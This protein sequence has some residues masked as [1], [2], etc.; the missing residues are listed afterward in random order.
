MNT[1]PFSDMGGDKLKYVHKWNGQTS[2]LINGD[3]VFDCPEG[4]MSSKIW[5]NQN[6]SDEFYDGW[7]NSC[8]YMFDT[9]E[10]W[11]IL[12]NNAGIFYWE[13]SESRYPSIGAEVSNINH[14]YYTTEKWS[15]DGFLRDSVVDVQFWMGGSHND[16]LYTEPIFVLD[17]WVSSDGSVRF[18]HNARFNEE[19]M[20]SGEGA[21]YEWD[22]SYNNVNDLSGWNVVHFDG[23]WLCP[24]MDDIINIYNSA[25]TLRSIGVIS[26]INFD[27]SGWKVVLRDEENNTNGADNKNKELNRES[28]NSW[29]E[30]RR[31]PFDD[32]YYTKEEFN[33]YYG[34]LIQWDFMDPKKEFKRQI[35]SRW[36]Y[37]NKD[38]MRDSA[39]LHLMDEMFKTFL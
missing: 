14:I 26:Q 27:N 36:I 37:D 19:A 5:D 38:Y 30:R 18:V 31:D 32:N 11:L 3:V 12:K 10:G 9:N 7:L 23:S 24:Q 28:E 35:I 29:G 39:I 17:G 21:V 16:S 4:S 1:N 34:E 20:A 2:S 22:I 8:I 6:L 25:E 33:E 13:S 15:M